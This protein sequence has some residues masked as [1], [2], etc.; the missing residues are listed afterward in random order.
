MRG[1]KNTETAAVCPGIVM[2]EPKVPAAN[3]THP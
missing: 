3:M 2:N 1:S